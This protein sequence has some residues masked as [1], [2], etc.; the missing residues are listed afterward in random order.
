MKDVQ[1]AADSNELS[2]LLTSAEVRKH[3]RISD[4]SLYRWS[5][6]PALEFPKPLRI[7]R[8]RFWRAADIAAFDARQRQR[9]A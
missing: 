2:D 8:R 1:Q 4:M 6:D 7:N 9:A 5:N 3:Y